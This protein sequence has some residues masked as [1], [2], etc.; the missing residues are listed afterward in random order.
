MMA[1][2]AGRMF[3]LR[4]SHFAGSPANHPGSASV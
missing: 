4:V 2:L 1:K 3:N